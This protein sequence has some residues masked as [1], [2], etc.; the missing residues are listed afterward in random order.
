MAVRA[1]VSEHTAS[2]QRPIGVFDSGLGGLTVVR[3]IMRYLPAEPGVYFGDTARVPYGTKS[4]EAIRRFSRQNAEVLL[5]RRVKLVVVA[6]N[7]SSSFALTALRRCCPVPVLGVIAPGVDEAL[8]RTRSGRVGVI[9]T[10]A[11]IESRAYEEALR[12]GSGRVKVFARACPLFVPLAEEGWFDGP[13]AEE[14]ARIYLSPLKKA[15]VDT[16]ILGCTHYPLLKKVIQ[17]VM[18]PEVRL[19]DSARAV[20]E[21]VQV[22][23]NR[24]RSEERSDGNGRWQFLVSDRPQAFEQT[25]RRFLGA[26]R[27]ATARFRLVK[28]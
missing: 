4:P 15:R 9:A 17:E 18:G 2:K 11:T 14:A 3:E 26:R 7:S 27:C 1:T 8:K 28:I 20:A 13:V 12:K 24:G 19:V 25:A 5:K 21:R 22:M 16:V 10:R 23:L 6:C